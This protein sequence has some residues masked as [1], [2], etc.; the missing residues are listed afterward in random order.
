[1]REIPLI[2]QVNVGED[3]IRQELDA[4]DDAILGDLIDYSK[5]EFLS[6]S[7]KEFTE[8][9]DCKLGKLLAKFLL[10]IFQTLVIVAN[11]LEIILW[12]NSDG[13]KIEKENFDKTLTELGFEDGDTMTIEKESGHDG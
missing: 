6:R 7:G 12:L 10:Y 2:I 4:E 1:M 5:E 11:Y 9:V 8:P 3:G 13:C